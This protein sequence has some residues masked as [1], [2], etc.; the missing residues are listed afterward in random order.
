MTNQTMLSCSN[1]TKVF[2]VR[3]RSQFD[4]LDLNDNDRLKAR[5]LFAAV[6]NVTFDVRRGETF[7]VMGLSG[8]GKSTLVRCLTR[9]IEPTSGTIV[10]D[11]LDFARASERE[12]IEIR[13]KK[14]GMVFQH[15][16]LL[17]NR[18]VL[19]N[20]MF[21]LEIQKVGHAAAMARAQD[22]ITT[23]GL[24]GLEKRFPSEMSGGQQQRVGIARSLATDP[25]IWFLD[26]PFSALDPLIRADLQD[27]LLRLQHGF[28]KTTV[29]ITHDLD[30]A[31]KIADRIAIMQA[32]AMIQIGT[33]E[34]L[35]LKPANDYVQR[36]VSKVPIAKVVRLSSLIEPGLV[37]DVSHPGFAGS[38]TVE[39]VAASLL[40]GPEIVPVNGSDG[41]RLGFF[42]KK[43]AFEILAGVRS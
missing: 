12:V 37:A 36:F 20:I 27:E 22:L 3:A 25:P 17:P 15:F 11:G 42:R 14:M 9:L 24:Q 26:E 4:A 39:T 8:S 6:K 1:L 35:I 2:G 28:H 40:S 41:A 30:E 10:V 34:E 43:K 5:G 23:V 16:A 21:P 32:G 7:V 13:R 18:S 29:F 31:V 38:D 33:P 19:E